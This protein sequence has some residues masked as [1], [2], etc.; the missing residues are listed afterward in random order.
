MIYILP[1]KLAFLIRVALQHVLPAGAA[2]PCTAEGKCCRPSSTYC[3]NSG[4]DV[5]LSCSPVLQRER[6]E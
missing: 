4:V 1:L 3:F 6:E 2:A 5:F